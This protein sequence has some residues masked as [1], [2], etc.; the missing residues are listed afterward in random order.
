MPKHIDA[1]TKPISTDFGHCQVPEQKMEHFSIL[2]VQ[3]ARQKGKFHNFPSLRRFLD[4]AVLMFSHVFEK[5]KLLFLL[6]F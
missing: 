3:N 5:S 1:A 4:H 6:F 2:P